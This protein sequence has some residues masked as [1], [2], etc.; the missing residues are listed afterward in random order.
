MLDDPTTPD[1]VTLGRLL[2]A[3]PPDCQPQ[4]VQ[5]LGNAAGF[6]GARLWKLTTPR[7]PL[8]WRRWPR[9]HPTIERLEWIHRVLDRVTVQ[10]VV[11]VPAP[12]RIVEGGTIVAADGYLWELTPWL[13]GVADFRDVPTPER[14]RA[15]MRALAAFHLAAADLGATDDFSP[16]V[17]DRLTFT[18]E[19]LRGETSRWRRLAANESESARLPAAH[20]DRCQEILRRAPPLLPAL[21]TRLARI[22]EE[23]YRLQPCLRDI[24]HDHVLF[25]GADVSGLID[26]GALRVET[27]AGDV[28]RLLGSLAEND[29]QRWCIGLEAYHAQRPLSAS[30]SGAVRDFDRANVVLSGLNWVRWLIVE[31]R[32][33][34]NSDA[35]TQRLDAV[36]RRLRDESDAG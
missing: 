22:A 24:W 11:R 10:G 19:L 25:E 1:G 5:F 20:I 15:A 35:V 4:A 29:R 12:I 14:L 18:N 17:R 9:E 8:C 16:G 3:Y 30:E 27:V 31:R 34:E 36:L 7:G 32:I 26:F 23:R 6:S 2:A 21:E 13:P 28:A 33:F